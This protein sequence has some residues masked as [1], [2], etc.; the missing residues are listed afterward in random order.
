MSYIKVNSK[1]HEKYKSSRNLIQLVTIS[2]IFTLEGVQYY[3]HC[4]LCVSRENSIVSVPKCLRL[5]KR[6]S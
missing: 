6:D 1:R 5:G 4:Q 2:N 3:Q